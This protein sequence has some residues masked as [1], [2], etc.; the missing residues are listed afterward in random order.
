ME[1]SLPAILTRSACEFADPHFA[2]DLFI[3]QTRN[4]QCHDL[5]FARGQGRV[6]V[7]KIVQLHFAIESHAA[8]LE[9]LADCSQQNALAAWFQEKIDGSRLYGLHRCW[10]ILLSRKEE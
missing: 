1:P 2:A 5:P 7:S 4:Y 6:A 9:A 3:Q 8:A 10:D